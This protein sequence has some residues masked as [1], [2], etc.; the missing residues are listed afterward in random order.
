M[1]KNKLLMLVSF[2][3]SILLSAIIQVLYVIDQLH[4]PGIPASLIPNVYI[5]EFIVII[6]GPIYTDLI[7]L[8]ILPFLVCAFYIYTLFSSHS[9]QAK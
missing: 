8:Y 5:T 6:P 4:I 9:L 2:I 1:E 7:I 3:A